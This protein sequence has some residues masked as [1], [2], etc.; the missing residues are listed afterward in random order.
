MTKFYQDLN[1]QHVKD[2][3]NSVVKGNG[4]VVSTAK[5]NFFTAIA[6]VLS[7]APSTLV[8]MQAEFCAILKE[9]WHINCI[10]I[11]GEKEFTIFALD[12][13][14][15]SHI[16]RIKKKAIELIQKSRN[17]DELEESEASASDFHPVVD[18]PDK[19]CTILKGIF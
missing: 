14:G 8:E 9:K 15:E 19:I 18:S 17:E 16:E 10:E 1:R 4:W 7:P 6:D 3:V 11:E 2:V 13:Y 5:T 12:T